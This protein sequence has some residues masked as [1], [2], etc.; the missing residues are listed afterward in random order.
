LRSGFARAEALDDWGVLGEVVGDAGD[1]GR[2]GARD[3]EVEVAS[4]R[5]GDKRGEI[6]L[7]DGGEILTFGYAA[8]VS[9]NV[10]RVIY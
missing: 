1:E 3:E 8:N 4:M 9:V 7:G 10:R 6:F 2:F 5:V